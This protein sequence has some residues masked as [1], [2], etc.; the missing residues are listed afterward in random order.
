MSSH[1]YTEDQLV[2]QTAANGADG[3]FRN[4]FQG[5]LRVGNSLAVVEFRITNLD[6]SLLSCNAAFFGLHPPN[7]VADYLGRVAVEAAGDL[8]L[9]KDL[10]LGREIDVHGHG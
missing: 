4:V 5:C 1:A 8:G 9:D 10:H 7:S 2:E 6:C 3:A